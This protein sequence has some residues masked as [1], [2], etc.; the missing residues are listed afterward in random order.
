MCYLLVDS[1]L[2]HDRGPFDIET[3]PLICESKSM[4]YQWTGF[5]MI[6]TS[7][8]KELKGQF[9]HNIRENTVFRDS[10]S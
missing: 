6:G 1:R 9:K 8:M 7:V 3:N 10:G 5:Y 2:L 4:D